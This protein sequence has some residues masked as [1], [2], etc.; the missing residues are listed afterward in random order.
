M[1]F[2]DANIPFQTTNDKIALQ[3]LTTPTELVYSVDGTTWTS[4]KDKIMD[5]NVVITNIPRGLYM[6]LSDPCV[7]TD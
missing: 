7:I 4:W 3:P 2:I 6:R 5:N 1:K